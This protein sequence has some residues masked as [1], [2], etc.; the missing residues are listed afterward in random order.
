MF[1]PDNINDVFYNE[2]NKL[3]NLHKR[4]CPTPDKY[5]EL[6]NILKFFSENQNNMN[7]DELKILKNV[8]II[9]ND[10]INR[11][12]PNRK[13]QKEQKEECKQ[14]YISMKNKNLPM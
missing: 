7:S 3:I 9:A 2:Y 11:A 5:L 4:K 8:L 13:I 10:L 14:L 1:N 6:R 12:I